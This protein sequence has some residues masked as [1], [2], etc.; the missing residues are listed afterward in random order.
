MFQKLDDVVLRHEELT[1]LLMDPEVTKDP[2][3]IMEYNKALNSIDEVVKKY[4]Y[5]KTRKNEMISLKEDIKIEKD[6]EMKEMML[7]E[8]KEIEEEMPELENELKILLLPK[9]PNDDKNVIMEIRAGAGGDEAALFAADVFRM[10][11]I[12]FFQHIL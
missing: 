4:T 9:D 3:K 12:Y 5:Y 7:E 11:S 8:I 1:N 10:F 2:K 6:A